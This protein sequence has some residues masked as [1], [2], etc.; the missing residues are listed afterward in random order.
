MS[1]RALSSTTVR[2]LA[3]T[4]I[5]SKTPQAP[6]IS[7]VSALAPRAL[8]QSLRPF[9]T[10]LRNME[11]NMKCV[12]IKDGKGPAENLYIGEEPVPQPQGD[13]IQVEIKVRQIDE[14]CSDEQLTSAGLR[15]QPHGHRS[16]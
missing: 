15:S 2:A 7:P 4:R 8:T 5:A 9:S 13:E 1:V 10:T 11:G 6:R 3:R 14:E 12:L 16:A